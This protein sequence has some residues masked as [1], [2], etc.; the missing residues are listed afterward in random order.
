MIIYTYRFSEVRYYIDIFT[1]ENITSN[2][3]DF[4][5]H[6]KKTQPHVLGELI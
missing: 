3:I 1:S 4:I 6:N 5:V 2:D